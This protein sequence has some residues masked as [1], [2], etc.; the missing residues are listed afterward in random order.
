MAKA[1]TAGY[2]PMGAVITRPEIAD[3]LPIFRHV[4]TF[5]G[6][7]AA[8]AAALTVIGIKERDGLIEKSRVDGEYFQQILKSA[9]DDKPI[10]GDVRGIGMWH[11]V[12]FTTDKSTRQ[13]FEDDTVKVIVRRMREHGVIVGFIGTSFEMAPPLIATRA[14]LDRTAEVAATAIDEVT[15]ERGLG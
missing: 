11:A 9:L 7:A 15:A 4:H 13:P 10:V 8:A 12:D 3:S 6:H 14:D 2:M 1:L 5:S